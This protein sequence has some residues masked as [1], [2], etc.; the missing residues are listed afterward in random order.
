MNLRFFSFI[1]CL[2]LS[3]KSIGS[4]LD[5][6]FKT[7]DVSNGLPHNT[8]QFVMQSSDGFIWLGTSLGLAKFDGYEYKNFNTTN[9]NISDS[10]VT[11]IVEDSKGNL[12]VGTHNG[13][14]YFD[15]NKE[16]FTQF[17]YSSNV[18]SSISN[19]NIWRLLI[20]KKERLWVATMGGGLNLY[21]GNS[22]FKRYTATSDNKSRISS[23]YVSDIASDHLGNL[24]V[25]THSG[26]NYLNLNS[27]SITVYSSAPE[28][29]APLTI[30]SIYPLGSNLLI[31]T[32]N[33]LVIYNSEND[34]FE[35]IKLTINHKT[36]KPEIV[37]LTSLDNE[38]IWIGTKGDGL[39]R[40][41]LA[42]S[43]S[44]SITNSQSRYSLVDNSIRHLYFDVQDNLWIATNGSGISLLN[45]YFNRFL[46]VRGQPKRRLNLNS[47][48]VISVLELPA[49]DLLIGTAEGLHLL[50]SSQNIISPILGL[51]DIQVWDIEP[52][53]D[54]LYWLGTNDGLYLFDRVSGE[55]DKYTVTNDLTITD[56]LNDTMGNL[57]LGTG[58]GLYVFN[59]K[60]K[61]FERV[62]KEKY[63]IARDLVLDKE[64]RIWMRNDHDL[65]IYDLKSNNFINYRAILHKPNN[66]IFFEDNIQEIY[67]DSNDNIWIG[68]RG[69]GLAKV[70]TKRMQIDVFN[71]NNVLLNN[72]VYS[73]LEDGAGHIWFGTEQGF[74][75]LNHN[76]TNAEH[77]D[78]RDGVPS[79]QF[80]LGKAFKK[81][82]GNLIFALTNGY[83]E[84]N[85]QDFAFKPLAINFV[86]SEITIDNKPVFFNQVNE[87][88][89]SNTPE[90]L[91]GTLD[92]GNEA[93]A[94]TFNFSALNYAAPHA[95]E[96][97]YKLEGYDDNWLSVSSKKRSATYGKLPTGTYTFLV[98]LSGQKDIV[99]SNTL[100]LQVIVEPPIWA[101]WWAYSLYILI[102]CGLVAGYH[103]YQVRKLRVSELQKLKLEK[104]V[105]ERTKEL[106]VANEKL[107]ELSLTD[108]LT[109]LRNRRFVEHYIANDI[110]LLQ[111]KSEAENLIFFIVDI[112]HFKQINDKYG[113]SVG[114][115]V[116]IDFANLIEQV[117]RKTDYKVRWG[118]EEFLL[119]SRF[120]PRDEAGLIAERLRT[121]VE[122]YSFI[123]SNSVKLNVTCS[124]GFSYFPISNSSKFSWMNIIQLADHCLYA[125]KN[126]SRNAW[127]G[128]HHI[129]DSFD[130]NNTTEDSILLAIKSSKLSV[131]SS[132]DQ[133][134]DIKW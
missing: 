126:T 125:A 57:W 127:V 28:I 82:N 24:W 66:V 17:K 80:V 33:G 77:F 39:F 21:E 34:V 46:H 124:I 104:S 107:V 89:I 76:G 71:S 11:S 90:E 32:T 29:K 23:N 112:D 110:G 131:V 123:A 9:S 53:L 100:K 3:W 60:H 27:N 18:P 128:L 114:D 88:V 134:I 56:I 85:P 63:G 74:T 121:L 78:H 72:N 62:S 25:A 4:D 129:D 31:G 16:K 98:R 48:I 67:K 59:I 122:S 91:V 105:A 81:N 97:Q 19:D 38:N 79:I 95:Y 118:G 108:Q 37:T 14:N 5:Y 12:W 35:D 2:L 117:F 10:S 41:N 111:R 54:G 22:K 73:I 68:T 36:I 94:I 84:F 45:P 49:N 101:T 15:V 20:D 119:V 133:K 132:I 92:V 64:R 50:D 86:F 113:H 87:E 13:L 40:Y 99:K 52:A 6:R 115:H 70:D 116:L 43:T 69:S 58:N 26:L 42:S 103:F 75:R 93:R 1:F 7:L 102:L 83:I 109:G 30:W 120:I 65:S 130:I 61:S 55:Y 8:V 96:Y 47:D 44:I 106:A 51:S